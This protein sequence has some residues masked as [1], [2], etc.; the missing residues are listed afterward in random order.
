M[1]VSKTY[2]AQVLYE[3][4]IKQWTYNIWIHAKKNM[5]TTVMWLAHVYIK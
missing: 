3:R 2:K 5:C 4:H 1:L